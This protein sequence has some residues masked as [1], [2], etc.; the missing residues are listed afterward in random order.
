MMVEDGRA[1]IAAA[2][3]LCVFEDMRLA[4]VTVEFILILIEWLSGHGEIPLH[5]DG[6]IS[7]V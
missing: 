6:P 5:P 7:W 3:V 4:N 1:P 2:A